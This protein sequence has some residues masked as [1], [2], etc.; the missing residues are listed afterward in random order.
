MANLSCDATFK[1]IENWDKV[2]EMKNFHTVVGSLLFRHLFDTHPEM[3]TVFSIPAAPIVSFEEQETKETETT[4]MLIQM[5]DTG[6]LQLCDHFV[7][8]LAKIIEVL[9]PDVDLIEENVREMGAMFAFFGVRKEHL[10]WVRESLFFAL[11]Y[12]L[13]KH[14]N[15]T[16]WDELYTMLSDEMEAK[17]MLIA[18]AAKQ[19]RRNSYT[20]RVSQKNYRRLT[21]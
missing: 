4:S 16:A 15:R 14:F 5:K 19:R 11:G 12:L 20:C 18:G 17:G 3:R 2:R 9:G 21:M 10:P 6:F 13:E 1:L 8:N 7:E